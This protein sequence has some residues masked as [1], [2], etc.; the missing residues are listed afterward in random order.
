MLITAYEGDQ[1][2]P[3]PGLLKYIS[4]LRAAAA[5]HASEY[6]KTDKD[7]VP[8]FILDVQPGSDHFGPT[9][10]EES[11]CQTARQFAFLYKE[12]GIDVKHPKRKRR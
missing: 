12:L 9:D 8:S 6:N 3:L 2:V 10:L 7:P 5:M 1:R 11:L 4:R